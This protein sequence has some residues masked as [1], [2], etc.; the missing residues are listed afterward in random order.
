MNGTGAAQKHS[1]QVGTGPG[2]SYQKRLSQSRAN[3][4]ESTLKRGKPERREGEGRREP[5]RRG[6]GGKGRVDQRG[7]RTSERERGQARAQGWR[8]R[9]GERMLPFACGTEPSFR[10]SVF[11]ANIVARFQG[12]KKFRQFFGPDKNHQKT[13]LMDI[14]RASALRY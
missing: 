12:F 2:N 11:G 5:E 8:E 3:I 6:E 14:A 7:E 1:C 4:V 10:I 9:T 13:T